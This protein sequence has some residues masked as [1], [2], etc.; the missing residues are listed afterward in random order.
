MIVLVC[1]FVCV[2]VCVCVCDVMEMGA[3][4]VSFKFQSPAGH[5]ARVAILPVF[6]GGRLQIGIPRFSSSLGIG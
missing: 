4:I 1:L 6:A 3:K 2:C 5:V